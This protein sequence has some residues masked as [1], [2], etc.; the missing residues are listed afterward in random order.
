MAGAEPPGGW[1]SEAQRESKR[2]KDDLHLKNAL[3]SLVGSSD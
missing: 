2:T 3:D 1:R